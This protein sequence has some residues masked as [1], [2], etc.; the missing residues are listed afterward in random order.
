MKKY[1]ICI[2]YNMNSQQGGKSKSSKSKSKKGG[3]FLG[4]VSELFVPTGWETFATTAGLFALDRADAA[5]RR[6]K[7]TKNSAKKGGMRGGDALSIY[8]EFLKNI[9]YS[10]N[11]PQIFSNL[12][13]KE[14]DLRRSL[15]Q[16]FEVSR[17]L[18]LGNQLSSN[19]IES[20]ITDMIKKAQQEVNFIPRSF[21][22]TKFKNSYKKHKNGNNSNKNYEKDFRDILSTKFKLPNKEIEEFV[23]KFKSAVDNS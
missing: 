11:Q 15:R 13:D 20:T 22:I 5:L 18:G 21:Y 4:S 23:S 14:L 3:N 10:S 2:K 1:Y 12:T 6:G 16:S 8:K 17:S 7:S 19:Q 9:N